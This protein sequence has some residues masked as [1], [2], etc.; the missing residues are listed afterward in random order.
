[1][2]G[3]LPR[4]LIV[5][6]HPEILYA[7]RRLFTHRGWDVVG[8]ATLAEGIAGLDPPPDSVILDIMLP[9]GSGEAILHKI[10][11]ERLPARVLVYSAAYD[12]G[13][14]GGGPPTGPDAVFSKAETR[15]LTWSSDQTARLWN[16]GTGAQIG[17][18]LTH[19]GAVRG[20]V[21]S[22]D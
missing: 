10:R 11:A 18:D 12:L 13:R 22:K 8:A 3:P 14:L 6:D 15:I 1:M 16:A 20:A 19:E 5:E 2:R 17:P 21:F 4:L 9:D 7:L